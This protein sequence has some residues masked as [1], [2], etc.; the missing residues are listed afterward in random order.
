[1]PVPNRSST[2]HFP[3]LHLLFHP[4]PP[5]D[6]DFCKWPPPMSASRLTKSTIHTRLLAIDRTNVFGI[7]ARRITPVYHSSPTA[8]LSS[9][10]LATPVATGSVIDVFCMAHV[11]DADI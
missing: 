5:G 10:A 7:Q 6:A 1:M 3:L 9:K 8:W 11:C 4:S 2:P